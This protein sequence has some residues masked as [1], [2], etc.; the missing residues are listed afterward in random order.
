M[1]SSFIEEY[2][3]WILKNP[4]LVNEKIK[5]IYKKLVDDIKQPKEVAFFNKF[6]EEKETHCYIFDKKLGDRPINFIEKY[7]RK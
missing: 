6:T 2:Y 4:K 5:T 1:S 3:S 7:C